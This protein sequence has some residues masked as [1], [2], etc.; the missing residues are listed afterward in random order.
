MNL[1]CAAVPYRSKCWNVHKGILFY[2]RLKSLLL[3]SDTE[4][5]VGFRANRKSCYLRGRDDIGETVYIFLP[6][7]VLY[8]CVCASFFFQT[9][10]VKACHIDFFTSVDIEKISL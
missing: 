9:K 7:I 1:E 6:V 2:P 5:S 3:C 8:V 10:N 4:A